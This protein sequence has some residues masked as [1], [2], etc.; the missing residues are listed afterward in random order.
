M[1][2]TF[3]ERFAR[4][5][6]EHPGGCWEWTKSIQSRG[7]GTI[8]RNGKVILA[9]RAAYELFNGPIP[10][11]A[12]VLHSCDNPRCVNPEHLM[13]GDAAQNMR[14]AVERKRLLPHRG[15]AH[16]GAKL[17]NEKVLEIRSLFDGGW[18]RKD[19]GDAYGVSEPV[20]AGIGRREGWAHIEEAV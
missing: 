9:H 5:Y 13:A 6:E 7:Y 19:I 20:V 1:A 18:G 16:G 4:S 15:E 10:D 11:G 12:H 2:G 17:T 8:G 3:E 14:E